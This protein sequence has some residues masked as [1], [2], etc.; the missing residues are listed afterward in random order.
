VI[1]LLPYWLAWLLRVV[2]GLLLGLLVVVALAAT[3]DLLE[4]R[5]GRRAGR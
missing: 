4:E 3:A 2:G 1:D 5:R